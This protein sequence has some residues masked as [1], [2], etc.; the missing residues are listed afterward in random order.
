MDPENEGSGID[1]EEALG[2]IEEG[3]KSEIGPPDPS[4]PDNDD[5]AAPKGE[6]ED[7][8]APSAAAKDTPAGADKGAPAPADG[9]ATPRP[10]PD[11]WKPDVA[12]KFATLPPDVQ[13]EIFRREADIKQGLAQAKDHTEVAGGFEKLL[14]P[15]AQLMNDYQVNPWDHLANLL[16]AHATLMFG[17]P[18]QK[19][20]LINSLIDQAGLDRKGLAEGAAQPYNA[21]E[22]RLIAEVN[23]L[24]QQLAGI[25]SHV[26][27]ERLNSLE[28]EI[29]AFAA[30]PENVYF[31]ELVPEIQRLMVADP[32]MTLQKA[33]NDAI[34]DNP[35]VRDKE[36]ARLHR[37]RTEKAAKESKERAD[38]ARRASAVNVKSRGV[39]RTP[40]GSGNWEDDLAS[41]LAEIRARE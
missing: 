29:T 21:N 18:E 6:G 35:I 1:M 20:A 12:A 28:A 32:K 26:S 7:K 4:E 30:R 25:S 3:L 2:S 38:A 24:K 36:I 9:A 5:P 14:M 33:Y 8:G 34:Y 41:D 13:E 23:G 10:A 17:K 22:Q 40:S 16:N 11:T 15:Y 19:T 39:G 27:E 31:W 37:E